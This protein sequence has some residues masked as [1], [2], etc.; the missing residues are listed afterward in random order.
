MDVFFLMRSEARVNR[1]AL[2]SSITHTVHSR[3]LRTFVLK[4]VVKQNNSS[5]WLL[6]KEKKCLLSDIHDHD[7]NTICQRTRCLVIAKVRYR[8]RICELLC[9]L[10]DSLT[11]LSFHSHLSAVFSYKND[12]NSDTFNP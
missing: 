9:F 11:L 2:M 5:L 4:N 6:G 12:L 7:V 3:G 10:T 8:H 1:M